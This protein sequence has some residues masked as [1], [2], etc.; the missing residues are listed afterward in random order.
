AVS[1]RLLARNGAVTLDTNT[2]TKADCT[3]PGTLAIT[4]PTGPV[5]LGTVPASSPTISGHLG[6]V[7]VTDTRTA[8]PAAWTT[9]V[10][11]TDFVSSAHTISAS[12]AAYSPGS[13][14][15]TGNPTFATIDASSMSSAP[16]SVATATSGTG[17]NSA[18]WNP[19]IT[20]TLPPA[21]LVVGRYTATITHSVA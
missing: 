8:N 7:T 9:A 12:S 18:S 14:T 10:T 6:T 4:A 5:S 2:V 1:G 11:C 3:P 20:I 15:T 16:A 13:L 19:T 21:G 17:N